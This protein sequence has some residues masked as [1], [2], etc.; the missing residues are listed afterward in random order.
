ME[1]LLLRNIGKENSH[2]IEVYLKG[3]G[4]RALRKAL[5]EMSPEDVIEEVKESGLRGRE[6]QVSLRD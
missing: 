4:Y 1:R 3:G 5:K 6:E 2:T